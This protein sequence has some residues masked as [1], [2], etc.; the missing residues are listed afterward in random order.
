MNT[1]LTTTGM[2]IDDYEDQAVKKSNLAKGIGIGVAG[3]V[4]GAAITAGTTYAATTGDSDVLDEPLTAEE[5]AKGAEV[6][7]EIEPVAQAPAQQATQ[8]TVKE[9]PAQP[10]EEKPSDMIWEETTNVYVG[11]EKVMSMEEG[12]IDGHDVMIID[13]DADGHADFLAYDANNNHVYEDDEI[14]KLTPLDNIHM[15]HATAH[16]R[17]IHHDGY[18]FGDDTQ[19]EDYAYNQSSTNHIHNNFED[20][21]TG[22]E[23]SRDF[24]ENNPDYNPNADVDYDNNE[25]YLAE[26]YSYDGGEHGNSQAGLGLKDV[27]DEDNV[28]SQ[29]DMADSTDMMDDSYDSMMNSEEFLG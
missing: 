18:F 16:E 20:E 1:N 23:Y 4:G 15:G 12:K 7:E 8:Q 28:A 13:S 25:Q 2:N 24:A 10:E 19:E 26:N 21:K 27:E 17:E 29:P 9:T 5:M 22:E 11:G 3:A 6:G 14:V